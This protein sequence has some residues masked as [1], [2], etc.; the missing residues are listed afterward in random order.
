MAQRITIILQGKSTSWLILNFKEGQFWRNTEN[1]ADQ[2]EITNGWLPMEA[3]FEIKERSKENLSIDTS[4][5]V[6]TLLT[7][8]QL[9]KL[10]DYTQSW[11]GENMKLKEDIQQQIKTRS[12]KL[13]VCFREL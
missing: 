12:D 7:G 11:E 9:S 1:G 6:Q 8:E 4:V 10:H 2:K 13:E 3:N 5:E